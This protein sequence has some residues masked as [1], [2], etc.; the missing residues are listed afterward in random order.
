MDVHKRLVVEELKLHQPINTPSAS[1]YVASATT[2]PSHLV[3]PPTSLSGKCYDSADSGYIS[4]RRD[5]CVTS[6]STCSSPI[7]GTDL[8]HSPQPISPTLSESPIKKSPVS[9][10]AF[11]FHLLRRSR[12]TFTT[13]Q[14]AVTYLQRIRNLKYAT[15]SPYTPFPS[16]NVKNTEIF[17][18]P[19]Q[20]PRRLFMTLLI[21]ASKFCN[22]SS[23]SNVA[24]SRATGLVVKEVSKCEREVLAWMGWGL[25]V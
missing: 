2:V 24:W 8:T 21:I 3:S 1:P 7:T 15:A 17:I 19:H 12:T 25:F 10:P 5:S 20:C 23:F 9:L 16:S 13:F 6:S 22:D 18:P 11:L 4:D 14:V